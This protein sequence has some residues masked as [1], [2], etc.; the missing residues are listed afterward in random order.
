VVRESKGR[1]ISDTCGQL[2]RRLSQGDSP[3]T[4]VH[5]ATQVAL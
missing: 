4:P 3:I 2:K 1:E 5:V